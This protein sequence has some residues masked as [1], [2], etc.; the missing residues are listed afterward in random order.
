RS[1][2]SHDFTITARPITVTADSGQTKVYGASDPT[3]FTYTISS[4]SLVSPDHFTGAL[5]RVSGENVGS[6][7]L[8]LGNLA[9]ADGNSGLNYNL[10]FVSHDFTITAR[11]ITVTADSGQTKVYGASD[12]TPFTYTISS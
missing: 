4:D 1:F 10:S 2:V 12:P 9:I 8:T 7:A 6:Y 3:P 5:S 11:P